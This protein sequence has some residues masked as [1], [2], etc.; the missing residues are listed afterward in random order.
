MLY[1]FG[2][3]VVGA[4]VFLLFR[5][6]I[7]GRENIPADGGAIFA[8][9]HR[10]YW[11][12]IMAGLACPRQLHFMAKSELF[13][14]KLFGR[15]IRQLGAF[16]VSRGRGDVGA[17]KSA[18]K[19]LSSG[20]IML[21]F[22]EGKRVRDGQEWLVD[23]K[24]GLALIATTAKVPIIPVYISGKYRWMSKITITI[25]EPITLE[26][27]YGQK[28]TIQELQSISSGVLQTMRSLQKK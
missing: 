17:I 4:V 11:D 7:V 1:R 20:E 12:V 15:L 27:Y 22:P 16:P 21:M 14:N 9:N 8:V 23:A 6:K 5:L 25:G 28:L 3:I 18:M 13:R 19:L 2:R 10:S 26:Q 24:P